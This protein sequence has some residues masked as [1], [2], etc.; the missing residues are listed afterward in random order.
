MSLGAALAGAWADSTDRIRQIRSVL[1]DCLPSFVACAAVSGSLARMEGHESSD[2]DLILVIDDRS[3]SVTDGEAAAVFSDVWKRLDD[4]G[5]VRPKPGGIF[6]E[7]ARW[8]Q[9]TDPAA[10]GRVDESLV[11]F[12]HRIQLLMDA[13]PVTAGERFVELQRA[14]L[15]WYSETHLAGQFGEPGPFHWLWQDVQR[16]W[17]SLRSRTCWV[18]SH[19]EAKAVVLNVKLRSSRLILVYAF[20]LT[21]QRIQADHHG[22][23]AMTEVLLTSLYLTP[24]ERLFGTHH[25]IRNWNLVWEYLRDTSA[26][27]GTQLPAEVR[28]SLEAVALL[29]EEKIAETQ[30][31]EH[32][33]PWLM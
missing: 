18:N 11:T 26:G 20:L 24:A 30:G 25:G 27:P 19:D 32:R 16:Y 8:T 29:V 2:I 15:D 7:C 17:R 23:S 6:A 22:T 21:L 9:L 12:G 14:L 1:Q 4:L 5:A 3:H 13:Q 33:L 28:S 31:A 10:K